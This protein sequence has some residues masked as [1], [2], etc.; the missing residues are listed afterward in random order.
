MRADGRAGR[1]RGPR[2][3]HRRGRRARRH[4]AGDAARHRPPAVR[5]PA[6]RTSPPASRSPARRSTSC[7]RGCCCSTCRSASTCWRG[8][9]TRSPRAAICSSRTTTCAASACCPSWTSVDE[10]ARV[11]TGAF[12]AAGA[13]VSRRARLPQLFAQAGVGTPD[14]TDVAGRIEP[15][16]DR[17]RH[18]GERRSA[19]CCRRPWRTA[20]PP[21][22]GRRGAGRD[23]PRRRPVRRPPDAVAAADRRLEAQGAG[24]TAVIRLRRAPGRGGGRPRRA[25]ARWTSRRSAGT[26]RSRSSAGS[27]RTTRRA[28]SRRASCWRCTARSRRGTRTSTAGSPPPRSG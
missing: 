19:A 21:R 18:A 22:Q 6:P 13:D 25:P 17:P 4:G 11:I 8:C 5:L 3:R 14:G 20:S 24:M 16:G 15:L 2:A 26:S 9:G 28:P 27:S 10:V 7:T 23:R 1:A 12:G